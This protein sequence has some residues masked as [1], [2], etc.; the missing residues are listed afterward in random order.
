MRNA[1]TYISLAFLGTLL[2]SFSGTPECKTNCEPLAMDNVTYIEPTED[3]ELGFDTAQYLPEGF[4][5]YRGMGADLSD[6]VFVQNEQEIDLGFN[7]AQ[8]LPIGFDAYEGMVF[9]LNEIE[10]I[11]E[12][13]EVE[14]DFN[15]Q[16]YLPENFDASSK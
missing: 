5:A 12:E 8:Y 9:N 3:I 4:D 13:E 14:I 6:V 1:T 10:Y 11:E 16:K 7:T 2:M 15:I